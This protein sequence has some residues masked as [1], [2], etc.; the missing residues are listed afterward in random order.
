LDNNINLKILHLKENLIKEI[1]NLKSLIKLKELYLNKNQIKKIKNLNNNKHID[2]LN[3]SDN[4]IENI[5]NLKNLSDNEIIISLQNNPLKYVFYTNEFLQEN[6]IQIFLSQDNNSLFKLA[7]LYLNY[8]EY[9]EQL[10]KK[11]EKH[12]LKLRKRKKN[13]L[14]KTIRKEMLKNEKEEDFD[15]KESDLNIVF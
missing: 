13:Q 10:K 3:L 14:L 8:F 7:E 4:K 15:M 12:Y 9:K 2:Y 6:D 5:G 1:K 11:R